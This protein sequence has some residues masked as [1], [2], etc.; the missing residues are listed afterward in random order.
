MAGMQG[1]KNLQNHPGSTILPELL[2]LFESFMAFPGRL[3]Q[4]SGLVGATGSVE[5]I[6]MSQRRS[7]LLL[8]EY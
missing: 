6:F 1:I 3:A 4:S 5:T 8:A 7:P 2:F